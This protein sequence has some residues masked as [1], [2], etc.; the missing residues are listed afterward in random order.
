MAVRG[1]WAWRPWQRQVLVE[2]AKGTD[3]RRA[4]RARS[5]SVA[6][7]RT[8]ADGRRCVGRLPE[9]RQ[10]HPD[11]CDQRGQAEDRRLSVHDARAEPRG[12]QDRR[13][14]GLRGRRHPRP[15]RR[16]QR[17]KRPRAPV[18]AA[19]RASACAVRHAGPRRS[20]RGVAGRAGADPAAGVGAVP[21]RV[22]GTPSRRR[23]HEGRHRRGRLGRPA[24]LGGRR[25][26][27]P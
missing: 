3:V 12:G 20:R 5:G 15:D 21:A 16:R 23:G 1:R 6:E 13:S 26:W 9:R 8:E 18:P 4:G 22:A 14:H 27:C 2:Q 24:D 10:E 25:R 19:H 11:Q 17:G 7:A